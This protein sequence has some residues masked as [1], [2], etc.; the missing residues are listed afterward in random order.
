MIQLPQ[1][2]S[3]IFISNVQ[4]A[5]SLIYQDI[6]G[7]EYLKKGVRFLATSITVLSYGIA[8][9][10]AIIEAVA[11]A[12]IA[13]SVILLQSIT[14]HKSLSRYTA[15]SI[16]YCLNCVGIAALSIACLGSKN[17]FEY[18][19]PFYSFI[20]M[21]IHTA[22]RLA[23]IALAQYLSTTIS[24]FIIESDDHPEEE[25]NRTLNELLSPALRQVLHCLY[26]DFNRVMSIP[27]PD[28]FIEE[29]IAHLSSEERNNLNHFNIREFLEVPE[30]HPVTR[31]IIAYL[32]TV[33]FNQDVI[34]LN[35]LTQEIKDYQEHLKESIIIAVCQFYDRGWVDYLENGRDA[36]EN[37]YEEAVVPVA[38]MAQMMELERAIHCPATFK[39]K[40]FEPYEGRKEKLETAKDLLRSI[41][42]NDKKLLI[43]RLIKRTGFDLSGRELKDPE[44][45]NDIYCQ[46]G[47]LAGDYHQGILLN[48]AIWDHRQASVSVQQNF[49]SSWKKGLEKASK[50][51]SRLLEKL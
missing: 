4:Y 34:F 38:H 2:L 22:I 48:E 35:S 27:E 14:Q 3:S 40:V 18:A 33:P 12:S 25:A 9:P 26:H 30:H 19:Y 50:S 44:S 15:Y 23:S 13:L 24:N 36:L 46:I 5:H 47:T 32:D 41:N 29:Y 16:T 39:V 43:E 21:V 45:F 11:S 8:I 51:D 49:C 6:S 28:C 1:P 37:F 31:L 10:L 7:N 42:P 17:L 20:P